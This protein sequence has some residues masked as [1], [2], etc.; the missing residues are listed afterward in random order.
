MHIRFARNIDL[1]GIHIK[2]A[3]NIYK[4]Y[5]EYTQGLPGIYKAYLEYM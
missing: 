5:S 1:S 3:R 2:F 4:T